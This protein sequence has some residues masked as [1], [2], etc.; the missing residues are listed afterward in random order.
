MYNGAT[1]YQGERW[2]AG[3]VFP[4]FEA[5]ERRLLAWKCLVGGLRTEGLRILNGSF[6]VAARQVHRGGV[7]LQ[8]EVEAGDY[9]TQ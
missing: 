6:G 4:G 5:G 9:L 2:G 3:K 1:Q 7:P 8:N